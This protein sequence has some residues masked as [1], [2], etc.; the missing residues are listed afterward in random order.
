MLT[1]LSAAICGTITLEPCTSMEVILIT[2]IRCAFVL[3]RN[4]SMLYYT[5]NY[6]DHHNGV[7]FYESHLFFCDLLYSFYVFAELQAHF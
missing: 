5:I 7:D 3:Y 2:V 4:T 6:Y 1:A